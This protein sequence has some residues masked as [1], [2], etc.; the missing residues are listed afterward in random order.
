MKAMKTS[1]VNYTDKTRKLVV[2]RRDRNSETYT[3]TLESINKRGGS[4]METL[5]EGVELSG[6]HFRY[7]Q[8][9]MVLQTEGYLMELDGMDA[10]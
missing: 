8:K 3:V 4:E 6:A 7:I 10:L 1:L 2:L 9:I 5:V